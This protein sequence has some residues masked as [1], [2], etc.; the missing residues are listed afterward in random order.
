LELKEL[1]EII[2]ICHLVQSGDEFL[3]DSIIKDILNLALRIKEQSNKVQKEIK[4][5]EIRVKEDR[6]ANREKD[7]IF[8][9]GMLQAYKNMFK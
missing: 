7:M 3:D 2:S 4:L 9:L 6:D 8:N 5:K 1:D